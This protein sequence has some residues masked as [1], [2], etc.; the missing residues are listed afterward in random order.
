[1]V[2][3]TML[4]RAQTPNARTPT[5]RRCAVALLPL[6]HTKMTMELLVRLIAHTHTLLLPSTIDLHTPTGNTAWV[7]LFRGKVGKLPCDDGRKATGIRWF[8]DSRVSTLATH[9]I[10][11]LV[12][13][14]KYT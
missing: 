9:A 6:R 14:N 7:F 4:A 11:D 10:L 2:G 1:V 12:R 5:E 13:P 3:P 8:K